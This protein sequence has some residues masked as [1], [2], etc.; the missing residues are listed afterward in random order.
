L[1]VAPAAETTALYDRIRRGE[2]SRQPNRKTG[3]ETER[4][5]GDRPRIDPQSSAPLAEFDETDSVAA[6]S[7]GVEDEIRLVTVLFAG[8]S[9]TE[10]DT[11]NLD[12]EE[13]AH[14]TDRLLRIVTGVVTKY[15][16]QVDRFVADRVQV[17]F[18]LL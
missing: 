12:P 15:E 8:L 10:S 16:T 6:P 2:F 3:L 4:E 18:G 14:E 17:V 1:K 11:W 13:T 7:S 9:A 5:A